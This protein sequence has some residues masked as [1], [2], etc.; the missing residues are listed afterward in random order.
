LK[1]SKVNLE[2]T[3]TSKELLS[4]RRKKFIQIS[5]SMLELQ[6]NEPFKKGGCKMKEKEKKIHFKEVDNILETTRID[7]LKRIHIYR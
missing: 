3:A 5:S 6:C 4:L 7:T 2:I 1:C